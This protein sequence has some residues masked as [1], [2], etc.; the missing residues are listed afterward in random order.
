MDLS[1][2]NQAL[3]LSN[4]GSL[5]FASSPPRNPFKAPTPKGYFTLPE[6]TLYISKNTFHRFSDLPAHI[7]SMIWCQAFLDSQEPR[8]IEVTAHMEENL[9]W[10]IETENIPFPEPTASRVV[11]WKEANP[12]RCA[13]EMVSAESRSVAMSIWDYCFNDLHE[14]D[15]ELIELSKGYHGV[16]NAEILKHRFSDQR[17]GKKFRQGIK[18][19]SDRDTI[20]L[21]TSDIATRTAL[22]DM[23]ASMIGL[24]SVERFAV[25]VSWKEN[26]VMERQLFHGWGGEEWKWEFPK[27]YPGAEAYRLREE[28]LLESVEEL[29]LVVDDYLFQNMGSLLNYVERWNFY[30]QDLNRKVHEIEV[31]GGSVEQVVERLEKYKLLRHGNVR[32]DLIGVKGWENVKGVSLAT[33]R[34]L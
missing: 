16:E 17:L 29:T 26:Y 28:P 32:V 12:R 31:I 21:K 22:L 13:L 14:P 23:R 5:S 8:I 19:L 24:K 3:V 30:G 20:Y 1:L 18:F 9:F 27:L 25:D 33:G 7:R 11:R 10:A 4:M 2:L 15:L 6:T 34:M